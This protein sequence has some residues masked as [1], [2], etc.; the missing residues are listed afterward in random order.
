MFAK[1]GEALMVFVLLS[2]MVLM[3]ATPLVIGKCAAD[4]ITSIEVVEP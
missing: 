2:G 4:V 3:V 1:L